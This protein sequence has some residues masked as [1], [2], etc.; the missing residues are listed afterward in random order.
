LK[1]DTQVL[2]TGN[3]RF[4]THGGLLACESS[5]FHNMLAI[6]Q[7]EDPEAIDECPVVHLNDDA[8][9]LKFFLKALSITGA[10]ARCS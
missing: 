5:V 3:A 9:D 6:P 10:S 1:D 4:L 7:S 8:R 2:D